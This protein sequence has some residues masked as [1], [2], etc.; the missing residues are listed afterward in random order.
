M[1][2]LAARQISELQGSLLAM[3]CFVNSLA[4]ALSPGQRSVVRA[5]HDSESAA[6][7]AALMASTAP[8]ATVSAFE[9]DVQRAMNVLGEPQDGAAR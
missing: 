3:E 7:R 1:N 8:E 2:E 6:F 9:R 5:F 4:E